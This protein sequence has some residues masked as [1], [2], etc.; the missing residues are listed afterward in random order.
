MKAIWHNIYNELREEIE[1]GTYPFQS[2]LPSEAVLVERF[3]CSHNTVRKAISVL[4][5]EGYVQ[6]IHGK[7]VR[8]IHQ[9]RERA[10]FEV[11]GIETF[12]ESM[13]RMHINSITR[14]ACFERIETDEG[15]ARLT[16][17]APGSELFH[18][19]RVRVIDDEAVIRDE[20]YFLA[21]IAPGL[22]KEIAGQSI[23]RYLEQDL[24]VSIGQCRREITVEKAI[25]HDY[26]LL[27][28]EEGVYLAVVTSQTF[29]ADGEM[30]E[31]TESRH[32]PDRF[33]FQ[34]VARRKT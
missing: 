8:V 20:N 26:E 29:T 12:D 5:D 22:T 33:A 15:L 16:G 23:Y 24:G 28:L 6:P 2:M 4:T 17:F 13:E 7:G 32:R 9:P 27:D 1:D 18:I 10:L 19:D 21:S 14:V 3:G 34:T 11:G 31:R 25:K 30:F